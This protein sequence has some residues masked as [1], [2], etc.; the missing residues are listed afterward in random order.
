MSLLEELGLVIVGGELCHN[1]E[2]IF[3]PRLCYSSL[4]PILGMDLA[5]HPA[6]LRHFSD[7]IDR[8]FTQLYR[9]QIY[10]NYI[11]FSYRSPF[12]RGAFI[13]IH[14]Y[15]DGRVAVYYCDWYNSSTYTWDGFCR[16]FPIYLTALAAARER[17]TAPFIAAV[18]SLLPQ[19]IAEEMVEE[20][21]VHF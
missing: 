15:Q 21:Y 5:T 4:E 18:T 17:L 19:P 3:G 11:K 10:E 14:V 2:Q 8:G 16:H 13:D 7:Y 1:G 9:A 6:V 12:E 20:I